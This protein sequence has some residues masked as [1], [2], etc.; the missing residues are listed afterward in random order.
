MPDS[1]QAV[2]HCSYKNKNSAVYATTT[3]AA[4]GGSRKKLL[5]PRPARHEH[6]LRCEM[7]AGSRNSSQSEAEAVPMVK[8]S[9]NGIHV[10]LHADGIGTVQFDVQRT[11]VVHYLLR[12]AGY[13]TAHAGRG[14][15]GRSGRSPAVPESSRISRSGRPTLPACPAPVPRRAGWKLGFSCGC[16]PRG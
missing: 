10:P 3:T 4:S 14:S 1:P 15:Y 7:Y 5:G 6:C 11:G 12:G 13:R 9:G 16:C 2:R 8:P